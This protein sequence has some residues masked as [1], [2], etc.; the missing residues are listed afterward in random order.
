MHKARALANWYHWAK[1]YK[2]QGRES[3]VPHIPDE[4]AL[5]VISQEEL[6]MLKK[7]IRRKI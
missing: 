6:D 2:K 4:M 1:F 3:Y 5:E 7:L